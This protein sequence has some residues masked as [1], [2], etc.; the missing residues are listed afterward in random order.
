MFTQIGKSIAVSTC[1]GAA[2]LMTASLS[3]G[4]AKAESSTVSAV[5]VTAASSEST[6]SQIAVI[7]PE[8]RSV[9]QHLNTHA[10]SK[11]YQAPKAAKPARVR[12]SAPRYAAVKPRVMPVSRRG[13]GRI[14]I[15]VAY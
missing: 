4:A 3:S 10:T 6:S 2:F 11:I 15:G 14:L 9:G 7:K 12:R 8:M 13:G 1:V 5:V